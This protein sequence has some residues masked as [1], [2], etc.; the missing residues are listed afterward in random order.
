MQVK[1]MER[2]FFS[3]KKIPPTPSSSPCPFFFSPLKDINGLSTRLS[4]KRS[5]L[6]LPYSLTFS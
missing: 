1:D 2:L 6:F 5:T 3:S 4:Y